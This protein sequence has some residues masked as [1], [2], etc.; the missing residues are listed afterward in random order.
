MQRLIVSSFLNI[1]LSAK[2]D[3]SAREKTTEN[4]AYYTYIHSCHLSEL[5]TQ[6]LQKSILRNS[7]LPK[8]L[9]SNRMFSPCSKKL[10]CGNKLHCRKEYRGFGKYFLRVT[11][12]PART[13]EAQS[14][15]TQN[16]FVKRLEKVST[17]SIFT[18]STASFAE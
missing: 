8:Y 11:I 3:F 12:K 4:E 15:L 10:P 1:Y 18:S 2:N 14:G 17:Y 16:I 5:G 13:W 7:A 9:A 6:T